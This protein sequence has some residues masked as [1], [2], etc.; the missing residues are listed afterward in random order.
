LRYTI[1]FH[2]W[3]LFYI[4]DLLCINNINEDTFGT[5]I[6]LFETYAAYMNIKTFKI[7]SRSEFRTSQ[8]ILK[9]L[10]EN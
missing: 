6:E 7:L 9:Y 3:K 4:N 8:N 2:A 10:R 1:Y 5:I